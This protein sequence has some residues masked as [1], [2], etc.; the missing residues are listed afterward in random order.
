[1]TS[2]ALVRERNGVSI[3]ISSSFDFRHEATI[4][5]GYNGFVTT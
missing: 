3:D 2:A 5:Y 1:M 4:C